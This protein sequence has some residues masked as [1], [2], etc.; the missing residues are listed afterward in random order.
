VGGGEMGGGEMGGGKAGR[1]KTGRDKRG[2]PRWYAEAMGGSNR[3]GA[4]IH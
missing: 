3:V 2:G 4:A 1:G